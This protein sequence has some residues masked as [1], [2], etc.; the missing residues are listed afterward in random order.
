MPAL[1]PRLLAPRLLLALTML[2]FGVGIACRQ[3]APPLVDSGMASCIGN[4]TVA[5]AGADL[6]RLR[7][8]SFTAAM[9]K[10]VHELLERY[11]SD[12]KL[13]IAWNGSDLLIV[14]RGLFKTPP[15]GA[16]AIDLGLA[17]TGSPSR[18]SA[19]VAQHRA[20]STGAPGLLDY[21]SGIDARSAVWLTVRGGRMLPLGGNLANLNLL[22]QDADFAGAAL[23]LGEQATLRFGA[24][25]RSAESAARLEERLRG[26]LSLA[27]E[28]EIRRPDIAR[29]LHAARIQRNGRDV[30]ATLTASP[31]AMAKLLSGF[32]R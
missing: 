29:L 4:D 11:G 13:M 7:A 18:V 2:A 21:G 25:G 32:S 15:E 1:H 28:A 9:G 6:D 27:A 3:T 5:L 10:S 8:S 26:F 23:D 30:S 14:E 19:A 12:A 31:D 17:A 16:T 20:G 22:L 24:R